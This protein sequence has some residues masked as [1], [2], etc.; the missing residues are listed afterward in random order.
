MR[1]GGPIFAKPDG[2]E[3]WAAAVNAAGYRAAYCPVA[4]DT[5]DETIKAYADAANKADIVIAEVG[6]WSNPLGPDAAE[7][8]AALE[9]CKASLAFCGQDWRALLCEYRRILWQEVGWT[10]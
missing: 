6:A 5:D 4:P 8:A 7:A 10:R 1:L 2:P 9:K 3:S